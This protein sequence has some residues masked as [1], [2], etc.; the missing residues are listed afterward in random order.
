MSAPEGPG[1]HLVPDL[2]P[3]T[4]SRVMVQ[5]ITVRVCAVLPAVA[6]R[7][8]GCPGSGAPAGRTMAEF[9]TDQALPHGTGEAPPGRGAE[10]ARQLGGLGCRRGAAGAGPLPRRGSST[11]L[12]RGGGRRRPLSF[13][14][15]PSRVRLAAPPRLCITFR[16]ELRGR[17]E[18]SVDSA[19]DLMNRVSG[20]PAAFRPRFP[21]HVSARFF[22]SCITVAFLHP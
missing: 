17:A 14:G 9:E 20:N 8:R 21:Q 3:R 16:A 15:S 4:V 10:H 7:G 12:R 11:G 6:R 2:W 5:T 1:G 19:C 22:R 18:P 13:L